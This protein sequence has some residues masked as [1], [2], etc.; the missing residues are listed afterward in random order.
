M[1]LL[2]LFTAVSLLDSIK[3]KST[4]PKGVYVDIK[5]RST[6]KHGEGPHALFRSPFANDSSTRKVALNNLPLLDIE[7]TYGCND[8]HEGIIGFTIMEDSD[9]PVFRGNIAHI[10]NV[11]TWRDAI[12]SINVALGKHIM[13]GRGWDD[14]NLFNLVY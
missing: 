6:L 3:G 14:F 7:V 9:V 5:V 8:G 10:H 11:K 1:E 13:P 2:E 4:K 12:Q